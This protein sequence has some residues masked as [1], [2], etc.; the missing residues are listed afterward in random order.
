V[1]RGPIHLVEAGLIDQ[2]RELGWTVKFDGHHQFEEI[3]A[4]DD[5][6]IGKVKNPRLVSKV[7]EAVAQTVGGHVK[8]G[9]LP[10]TL[11]GDHSLVSSNLS[12]DLS[13]TLFNQVCYLGHGDHFGDIGVSCM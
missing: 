7:T 5:P 2:L 4:P 3:L 11:G 12:S 6:P 1:D 9:E 10:V 8:G 13:F